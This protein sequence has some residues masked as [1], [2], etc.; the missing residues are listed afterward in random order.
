MKSLKLIL[1]L[2]IFFVVVSCAPRSL[3]LAQKNF[4]MA[5]SAN[6]KALDAIHS[7]KIHAFLWAKK[8]AKQAVSKELSLSDKCRQTQ[9]LIKALYALGDGESAN[10]ENPANKTSGKIKILNTIV[11]TGAWGYGGCRDYL[12]YIK[13]E[14]KLDTFKFRACPKEL[15]SFELSDSAGFPIPGHLYFAG[16]YFYDYRFFE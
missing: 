4:C 16:W 14:D 13:I 3:S 5:P 1:M 2:F 11:Q 7:T 12:S 8:F 9:I 6:F 15:G 10:W